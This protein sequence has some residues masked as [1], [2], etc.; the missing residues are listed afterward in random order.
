M[1]DGWGGCPRSLITWVE[2]TVE[3]SVESALLQPRW[4]DQWFLTVRTPNGT[5]H[6][7]LAR[8]AKRS[9]FIPDPKRRL[10]KEAEVLRVLQSTGAAVPRY[11]G[12]NE[13]GWLLEE[14]V[15]GEELL[16]DLED[17]ERQGSIFRQYLSQLAFIHRLDPNQLGLSSLVPRPASFE[18]A[19]I[20]Y[21][22][23]NLTTYRSY[24]PTGPEPII[25]LG[26]W[27]IDHNP[28]EPRRKFS[29]LLGDVGANQ[30][31][32]KG[33]ELRCLF[34]F[35]MARIGDPMLDIG[36]MRYRTMTYPIPGLSGHLE[37]YSTE[38]REP[39]D[40]QRAHYWTMV[41][42]MSGKLTHWQHRRR[43]TSERDPEFH[44]HLVLVAADVVRKRGIVELLMELH[45]FDVPS[46]PE[47]PEP[48]FQG[49]LTDVLVHRLKL[50]TSEH[51][52]GDRHHY[53]AVGDAA[54]AE[55]LLRKHRFGASFTANLLD[56][57]AELLGKRPESFDDGMAQL[58]ELITR[59]P[60][61]KLA[62]CLHFLYHYTVLQ[63]H[64]YAPIV[65]SQGLA[66]RAPLQRL[67]P[68]VLRD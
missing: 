33:D 42:L 56:E 67:T 65:K 59:D 53:A 36:M 7:V 17:K 31:F 62:G 14:W 49:D 22:R 44:D 13:S 51:G 9:G 50:R 46:L 63:E 16:T 12:F 23:G 8:G 64:I 55:T 39:L 68:A 25:C 61:H 54:V 37:Y 60:E 24:K 19:V 40:H 66:T 30:F 3:G 41:C 34:D 27:W 35:E 47:L 38:L 18:D 28:L 48:Q 4:R 10:A 21:H 52:D 1:S 2:S 45:A 20:E 5:L 15:E 43:P 29:L 57:L 32:F 11:Y 58:E 6:K 26:N